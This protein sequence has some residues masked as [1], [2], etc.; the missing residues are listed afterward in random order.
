MRLGNLEI[1][2]ENISVTDETEITE[3]KRMGDRKSVFVDWHGSTEGVSVGHANQVT[4]QLHEREMILSFFMFSPP[5]LLGTQEDILAQAEEIKKI[6]P[7]CIARISIAPHTFESL[8]AVMQG[9]LN[10]Y[11]AEIGEESK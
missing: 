7:E 8:I 2:T 9:K 4:V 5:I 1:G 3:Q 6:T 10:E 11:K